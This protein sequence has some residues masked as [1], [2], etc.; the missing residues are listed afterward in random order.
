MQHDNTTNATRLDRAERDTTNATD[1]TVV[2]SVADAADLLGVS[3]GA[4]RKR[5]ER[6]QL[7]GRKVAGQWRVVLTKSEAETP[8]LAMDAT[9]AT[10]QATPDT[11]GQDAT[12]ATRQDR[13]SAVVSSAQAEQ[14]AALVASIQ[15]PL[16]D[17]LEAAVVRAVTAEIER[18]DL[19]RQVDD[20]RGRFYLDQSQKAPG[21]P[22]GVQDAP[23]T[24]KAASLRMR[25]NNETRGERR[26][27]FGDWWDWMRGR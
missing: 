11:T 25:S 12:N 26:S 2:L 18:D 9:N 10:R 13:T 8:S 3:V 4:I 21:S 7:S 22:Q 16:L 24:T 15:A 19:R 20:M 23:G 17:R 6:G 27:V 1:E 5:L 14:M